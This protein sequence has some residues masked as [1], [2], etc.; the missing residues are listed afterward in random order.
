MDPASSV[1]DPRFAYHFAWW[2]HLM[3]SGSNQQRVNAL[4]SE[5]LREASTAEGWPVQDLVPATTMYKAQSAAIVLVQGIRTAA[6]VG[7]AVLSWIESRENRENTG[8]VR[9]ADRVSD[10]LY[11]RMNAGGLLTNDRIIL[12]GHSYGGMCLFS[13][14]ARLSAERR[15]RVVSLV[16][17]GSPKPGDDRV[18]AAMQQVDLMRYMNVGDNISFCPPIGSKAPLMHLLLSRQESVTVNQLVQMGIGRVLTEQGVISEAGHPPDPGVFTDLSIA[19]FLVNNTAP[20]ATAHSTSE[21]ERRLRLW[22]D[23]NPP[24]VFRARAAANQVGVLDAIVQAGPVDAAGQ[25]ASEVPGLG[26]GGQIAIAQL[27]ARMLQPLPADVG[28]PGGNGMGVPVPQPAAGSP[29]L[30]YRTRKIGKLWVCYYVDPNRIVMIGRGKRE[31]K[32]FAARMNSALVKWD[33][34]PAVDEG[35]FEQS[36]IDAFN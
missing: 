1:R 2:I 14:A 24:V 17:F 12:A 3:F 27:P 10:T 35:A 9:V 25:P 28:V 29:P 5:E 19:N 8:M 15:Q 31:A 34:A 23:T 13:L 4:V 7:T 32:S 20:V 36:A 26:N 22:I 33:R 11:D 18:A 6:Q 21:Y 16:T 30:A